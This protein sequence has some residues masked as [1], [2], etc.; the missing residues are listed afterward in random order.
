MWLSSRL[1]AVNPDHVLICSGAQ[2][3]L[4]TVTAALAAPGETVCVE[5]LTYP[6]FLPLAA[7]LRLNLVGVPIDNEG[8]LPDA[9]DAA[10]VE[11][12]PKALYCTPTLHNPTTATLSLERRKALLSIARRHHVPIIED[13]AYGALPKIPYRPLASL[14]P[15]LVYHVASLSKCL[16]PALRIA[17]LVAPD[18]RTATRLAGGIRATAA[19]VSPLAA[20]IATRWIEDG[21][22]GSRSQGNRERR[23]RR[24]SRSRSKFCLSDKVIADPKGSTPGFNSRRPGP[25]ASS[26]RDYARP[27]LERLPATPLP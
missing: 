5:A 4:L 23:Q 18:L 1:E 22:A 14:A 3:A 7:H 15:E 26:S 20:S 25:V 9:F 8:L 21:T 10:C 24:V 17:Y 16:A 2:G 6:G 27:G 13:D 19:M 11:H 12:K